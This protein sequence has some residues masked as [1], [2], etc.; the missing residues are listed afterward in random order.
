MFCCFTQA[1]G[2]FTFDDKRWGQN[3]S[4]YD[5]EFKIPDQILFAIRDAIKVLL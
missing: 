1:F 5:K 4:P 3:Y 2:G